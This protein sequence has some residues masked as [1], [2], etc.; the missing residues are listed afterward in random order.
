MVRGASYVS[1]DPGG[2]A[3][4]HQG[5]EQSFLCPDAM[6]LSLQELARKKQERKAQEQ[7]T[8]AERAAARALEVRE[9]KAAAAAA[10]AAKVA[11]HFGG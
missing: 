10:A 4:R 6:L 7:E 5:H 11:T 1:C 8:K 9:R 2:C 3:C